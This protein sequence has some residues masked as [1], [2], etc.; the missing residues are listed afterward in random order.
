VL[1]RFIGRVT[2]DNSKKSPE[3]ARK[4]ATALIGSCNWADALSLL[5]LLRAQNIPPNVINYGAL[6][7]RAKCEFDREQ[8]SIK[9]LEIY[10][11]MRKDGVFPNLLVGTTVITAM[12]RQG[13][14]DDAEQVFREMEKRGDRADIKAFGA[15]MSAYATKGDDQA[16]KA[17]QRLYKEL[18]QRGH[19]PDEHRLGS[20]LLTLAKADREWPPMRSMS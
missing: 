18:I 11:D 12:G 2:P 4:Q 7:G 9:V 14:A 13:R 10:D 17:V 1:E 19:G 15:L 8:A 20:L 16:V 6:M 3:E 5:N